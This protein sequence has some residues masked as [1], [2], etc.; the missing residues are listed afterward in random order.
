MTSVYVYCVSIQVTMSGHGSYWTILRLWCC[1]WNVWKT[2]CWPC[3]TLF[4]SAWRPWHGLLQIYQ[5]TASLWIFGP[6]LYLQAI[7]K[8][9]YMLQWR[10]WSSCY[11]PAFRHPIAPGEIY[12]VENVEVSPMENWRT[13]YGHAF[14]E[15]TELKDVILSFRIKAAEN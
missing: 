10:S 13:I 6:N 12:T 7:G 9:D 1:C 11:T 15:S 8:L 14:F 4:S 2:K 5:Q 3:A